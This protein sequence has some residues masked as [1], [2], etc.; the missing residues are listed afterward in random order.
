[1]PLHCHG[2]APRSDSIA[3]AFP[4]FISRCAELL[5]NGCAP[6]PSARQPRNA[7]LRTASRRKSPRRTWGCELRRKTED[8]A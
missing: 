3:L 2:R 4:R 1:M 8:E 6:M 5:S 7:A